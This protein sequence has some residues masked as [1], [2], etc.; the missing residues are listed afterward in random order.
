MGFTYKALAFVAVA[1]LYCFCNPANGAV[2]VLNFDDLPY[3]YI[4][5]GSNYASLNWET[6]I[7]A[8]DGLNGVWGIGGDYTHSGL[9][10][11]INSGGTALIGISFPVDVD[12]AGAYFAK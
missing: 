11:V 8:S 2:T 9:R 7:P 3:G 5:T 12:V 1:Y 6:G 10:S 4:L